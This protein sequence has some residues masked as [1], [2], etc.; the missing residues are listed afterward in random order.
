MGETSGSLVPKPSLTFGRWEGL[1]IIH[2][3]VLHSMD[4]ARFVRSKQLPETPAFKLLMD[5]P[6]RRVLQTLWLALADPSPSS[7]LVRV[8]CLAFVAHSDDVRQLQSIATDFPRIDRSL[9]MIRLSTFIDKC[10]DP[11]Q[12]NDLSLLLRCLQDQVAADAALDT[13]LET[14]TPV[15]S[16]T[17]LD[18][19]D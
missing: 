10:I 19:L 17:S 6:A 2:N 5:R 4:S 18:D 16:L 7:E 15:L 8:Q 12:I 11:T 1:S 9:M 14:V 13:L 3:G